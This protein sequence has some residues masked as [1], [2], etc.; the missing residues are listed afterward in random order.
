MST[1]MVTVKL[2]HGGVFTDNRNY[3]GY[4]SH[5]IPEYD[6]FVC[7]DGFLP[8]LLLADYGY[9]KVMRYAF[10]DMKT[11]AFEFARDN[12]DSFDIVTS[13]MKYVDDNNVVEVFC[14]CEKEKEADMGKG[15]NLNEEVGG[16]REKESSD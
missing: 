3:N 9:S 2:W 5:D 1:L 14:E 12:D 7:G 6:V 10:R 16:R 8:E 15:P 11:G 13:V 4:Y